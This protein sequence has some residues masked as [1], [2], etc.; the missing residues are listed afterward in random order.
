MEL[1]QLLRRSFAIVP[2]ENRFHPWCTTTLRMNGS[3]TCER[4]HMPQSTHRNIMALQDSSFH[5]LVTQTY[6]LQID[7]LPGANPASNIPKKTRQ[8]MAPV[9]LKD[10][11]RRVD[12]TPHPITAQPIQ[13]LGGNSLEVMVAGTGKRI[14]PG[15]PK[16][17]GWCSAVI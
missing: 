14:Y 13:I 7:A 9:T 17:A 2:C 4:R 10:V 8:T 16:L 3:V 11:E 5:V 6:R 1:T 15:C 12:A